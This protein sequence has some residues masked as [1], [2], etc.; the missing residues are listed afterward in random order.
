MS[1]RENGYQEAQMIV[2]V[3][4]LV[5]IAAYMALPNEQVWAA[6]RLIAKKRLQIA[7]LFNFE[8]SGPTELT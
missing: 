2:V 1:E 7:L 3:R 4:V 8:A 5:V 6:G